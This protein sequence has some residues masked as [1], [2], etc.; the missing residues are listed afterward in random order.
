MR[1]TIQIDGRAVRFAQR[2]RRAPR[3]HRHGA[4]GVRAGRRAVRGREPGAQPE[5]AGRMAL[6]A[7]A[8]R[9]RCD[10][11]RRIASAWI[12]ATSTPRSARLPVGQRQ[13][14]EIVKALAGETRVLILDE[15]TAV[16]TPDRGRHA[17]RRAR[18]PARRR[19]RGALHHPQ[20]A[21]GHAHRRPRH[22]DAAAVASSHAPSDATSTSRRWRALM[23]GELAS[24]RRTA[25]R[26]RP[27]MRRCSCASTAVGVRR[28][29]RPAGARATSAS[30]CAPARSSA[31]PASTATARQS[32]SRC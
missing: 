5:P 18:P 8:G 25:A 23:V 4:P 21:R 28:R 11:A 17:L 6:A 24:R 31:S 32:S 22:R 12:S 19:H 7:R 9:R 26:R 30:R 29:R 20:A 13:R 16:L 14:L 2:A 27:A 10:A 1:G 3:R 15:P